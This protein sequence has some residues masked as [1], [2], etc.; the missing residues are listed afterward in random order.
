[1]FLIIDSPI[2]V[3][4]VLSQ[5]SSPENGATATFMGTVRNHS[6]GKPVRKIRYEAY[7]PMALK[8]F[9]KINL[10]AK[11]LWKISDL[12]IIHRVGMLSIG[13][14][15]VLV[16]ASAPHRA[17]ALAACGYAIDRVKEISPIWKKEFISREAEKLVFSY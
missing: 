14:I 13:E 11:V 10:E 6:Q 4:W 16:A 12:S 8:S 9:K 5:I 3:P 2:D 1:M 17:E 15:A 7:E